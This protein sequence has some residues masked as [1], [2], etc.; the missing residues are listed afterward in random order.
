MP[1]KDLFFPKI[2]HQKM[3]A[4]QRNVSQIHRD[5]RQDTIGTNAKKKP[6]VVHHIIC[7]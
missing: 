4:Q 1:D 6:L 3:G 2:T 5:Y 7:Q